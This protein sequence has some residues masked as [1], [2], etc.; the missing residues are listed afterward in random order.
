MNSASI[1]QINSKVVTFGEVMM[2]LATPRNSRFPQTDLLQL[3]F[4]GGEANVAISL[5]YLGIEASH[6]TC[7]PDN[8][9][10][11]AATQYLRRHWVNTS[12]IRYG[13][14]EMGI[15]F[16]EQG[17]VHRSST[18]VYDR[19]HSAFALADASIY[20]WEH[21]LKGKDWFHWT[22]ITPALS[23]MVAKSCL[24]AVKAANKFGIT[25]SADLALRKGLWKNSEEASVILRELVNYSNVIIAGTREL[26]LLL[27]DTK[28]S[29]D[30]KVQKVQK[31]YPSVTV[32]ADKDRKSRNAS[33][34]TIKGMLWNG[35]RKITAKGLEVTHVVDRVGTGDAFAAGLI[36]GLLTMEKQEEALDFA[37]AACA[38][39]H[40]IEGDANVVFEEEVMR[41]AS[42][43]TSGRI[44]R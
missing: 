18:I 9:I 13:G 19:S 32:I 43:D 26:D 33:I 27:D 17:A 23:R 7:F 14:E 39:K 42:G 12:Q 24:E 44:I 6:V 3:T 5:A 22:G 4:G 20:D 36:F 38:L 41:L 2:R 16:L 8:L 37:T 15:Y 28:G 11:K 34:N 35:K 21:I 25:V 31:L 10:G 1:D 40:T 29:L 30:E